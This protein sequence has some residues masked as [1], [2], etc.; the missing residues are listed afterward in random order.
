MDQITRTVEPAQGFVFNAEQIKPGIYQGV[1]NDEYQSGPGISKG[2]IDHA[3]TN[4]RVYQYYKVD[5]NEQR[6]TAAFREGK[7]LHKALLEFDDFHTEY[8][9]MPAMP[10]GALS[11]ADELKG[12]IEA[13]NDSLPKKPGT[14]ELVEAIEAFNFTLPKKPAQ[15]DLV[16]AVEAYN[17][18]L[19]QPVAA[20]SNLEDHRAAYELL[21][22]E[23]QTAE[24]DKATSL[25]KA[26]KAYN[27]SLPKPLKSKGNYT[28]LLE[29]YAACSPEHAAQA[30]EWIQCR[31]P[32]P[33]SGGSAKVMETYA[34]ISP[35]HAAQVAEWAEYPAPLS[36][37][38]TKADLIARIRSVDES[39]QF[40]DEIVAEFKAHHEGKE[41]LSQDE[42]IHVQRIREAVLAE[43]EAAMLLEEGVAEQSIYWRHR[44]T[45]ELLKCRPDW[46]TPDHVLVDAKF[47]LDASPAG[48]ARDGSKHNYHV[49]DAHYSE[50][51]EAVTGIRPGFV[52]IAIQKDAP[53]GQ[54]AFKPVLVGVYHYK[55]EDRTRGLALRDLGLT[56]ILRWRA[57]GYWPGY[58]GIHEIEVPQYQANREKAL[59]DG[60]DW[61]LADLQTDEQEEEF[62]EVLFS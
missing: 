45:G 17:E 38:G 28:T 1:S 24:D 43:P 19:P 61:S 56:S 36:M 16:T 2:H 51:Y 47:V 41:I 55:D 11:S 12:W 52:F 57:A 37:G 27:D 7:I 50:G 32:L 9:V 8:A 34:S 62:N 46:T 48:F 4:G 59:I 49:Q 40:V 31:D 5:G 44:T 13:Y 26:I 21:P 53:L 60:Y 29:S 22:A 6:E 54:E 25:K 20:G 30:A 3:L 58:D 23:W 18:G 39:V 15:A 42:W 10:E 14:Q 35:E 33:T